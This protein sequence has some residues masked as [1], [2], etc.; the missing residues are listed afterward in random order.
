[1]HCFANSSN[2][3]AFCFHF[4][5]RCG[6]GFFSPCFLPLPPSFFF[7]SSSPPS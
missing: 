4:I 5:V 3:F 7:F 1:V 6:P 2:L